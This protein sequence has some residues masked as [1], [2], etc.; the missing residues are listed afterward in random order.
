MQP[1]LHKWRLPYAGTLTCKSLWEKSRTSFMAKCMRNSI[2]SK[3]RT[4]QI[5]TPQLQHENSIVSFANI[6]PSATICETYLPWNLGE[7]CN[8][9]KIN[10]AASWSHTCHL[11]SY[12]M[13]LWETFPKSRHSLH[14]VYLIEISLCIA[15][16]WTYWTY[17]DYRQESYP[18]RIFL[19]L[20]RIFTRPLWWYT[21][22]IKP[23]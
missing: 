21:L 11:D 13:N 4:G 3:W 8:I 7:A 19:K 15:T 2:W 1:E 18:W 12:F 16:C 9:I 6:L 22:T 10:I 20:L 14:S 5:Y 23:P 17:K